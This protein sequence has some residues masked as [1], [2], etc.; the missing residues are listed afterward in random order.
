MWSNKDKY[1]TDRGSKK[2]QRENGTKVKEKLEWTKDVGE[3]SETDKPLLLS[4]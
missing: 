3:E 1:M 4:E 2:R